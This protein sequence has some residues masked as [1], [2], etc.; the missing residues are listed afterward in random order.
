M[1]AAHQHQPIDLA[2]AVL[3]EIDVGALGGHQDEVV[4]LLKV[5]ERLRGGLARVGAQD[6]HRRAAGP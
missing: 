5:R 6:C 4:I 3:G 1:G 2:P